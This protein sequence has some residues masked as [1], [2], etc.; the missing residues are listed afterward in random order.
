MLAI[1]QSERFEFLEVELLYND[2][3]FGISK[4]DICIA[5]RFDHTQRLTLEWR[6]KDKYAPLCDVYQDEVKILRFPSFNGGQ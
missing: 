6:E 1:K 3:R 4:G 2:P 5:R